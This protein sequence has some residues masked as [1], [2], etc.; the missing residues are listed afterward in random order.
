MTQSWEFQLLGALILRR[1]KEQISHF[2]TEKAKLL[3]AYLAAFPETVHTRE[4]LTESF[5]PDRPQ[6]AGRVSLRQAL[7]SLRR[8]LEPPD[9]AEGTILQA[10]RTQVRLNPDTFQTDLRAWDRARKRAEQVVSVA[11]RL[12]CLEEAIHCYTG[13]L[14]PGTYMEW[15][16]TERQH[17]QEQYLQVL[18]QLIDIQMEWGDYPA[19]IGFAERL[20][21][22]D[23]L[24]EEANERLMRLFSLDGKPGMARRHYDKY[25]HLLHATLNLTPSPGIQTLSTQLDQIAQSRPLV[26]YS[27]S[28][29][30]LSDSS[31]SHPV[32][33]NS[34]FAPERMGS[35]ELPDAADPDSTL[36]ADTESLIADGARS[37][38]PDSYLPL[39]TEASRPRLPLQLTRFFG[40]DAELHLL[41]EWLNDGNARLITLTGIGGVGKT[42]LALEAVQR[43][44]RF[45]TAITFVAL[46][47]TLDSDRLLPAILQAFG[48]PAVA[49][50]DP[51]MRLVT[52]LGTRPQLLIL[53]NFEQLDEMA[54][55][56]LL[57]LLAEIPDVACLVTSRK[58]LNLPGE[59]EL[60]LMPL[61]LPAP[62]TSA[63]QLITNPT[64]QMLV[65]RM[66]ARRPD[67]QVTSS[68]AEAVTAL[69][70][71]LEG[72]PLAVELAAGWARDL[73]VNQIQDR[74]THRFDL[75]VSRQRGVPQRHHSLLA[76][77]ESSYQSLPSPLQRYFLQLSV[78]RGGWREE[79]AEIACDPKDKT[80]LF[81]HTEQ[82]R[83]L[84]EH[85]LITVREVGEQM[86]YG[87]L[88]T[89][90]A[91][92]TEMLTSET[93]QCVAER[94]AHWF[95]AFAQEAASKLH[96]PEQAR[97]L[98]RLEE[99]QDNLRAA[100]DY[101]AKE[102]PLLGLRLANALYWFWYVRGHFREGEKWL[103]LLLECASEAPPFDRA[104]GLV[105]AGHFANCQSH[106]TLAISRYEAARELFQWIGD[107]HGVAHTLCRLGN[108]AQEM[109][110]IEVSVRH[111]AESVSLFRAIDDP[112]G[113]LLA[114]FYYANSLLG[115]IVNPYATRSV[116][117]KLHF[118]EALAIAEAREDHRFIALLYHCL[119]WFKCISGDV[120]GALQGY[121]KALQWQRLLREPLPLSYMLRDL[122]M[123]SVS[124]G[125]PALATTL[126]GAMYGL[127]Q[128][129]SY[130]VAPH[131]E[132]VLIDLRARIDASIPP[133]DY[134]Q[135]FEAGWTL[136]FDQCLT[137]ALEATEHLS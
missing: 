5:W 20:L 11:E 102:D 1:G 76:A 41:E 129:L 28:H 92:G 112:S 116:Q 67:F 124:Q 46:S 54:A 35:S 118:E 34:S 65:D 25:C 15:A 123:L 82:L 2:P 9:V 78:F 26:V 89:L 69:C 95:L 57:R 97:W 13:P 45:G 10:N 137:L 114:L 18:L 43:R 50:I 22:T 104:W 86:R 27:Q 108:A 31:Q 75:L 36:G 7:S 12:H 19:A 101:G 48:V 106:N 130:P 72:I 73:T 60:A 126:Y 71:R 134:R 81:G 103:T 120:E 44:T 87:M 63:Q 117:A 51:F 66:R 127:R 80:S 74:L 33:D 88:E 131:E 122:S 100:L 14:L 32:A 84:R 53:D 128:R 77:I 119:C 39:A 42:R 6:E 61:P 91:F 111:C 110:D 109:L 49:S 56:I 4:T 68:N 113:L 133:N 121:R 52:V 47:E 58:A 83:T 105:A 125:V 30:S 8:L 70:G 90:R 79:M 99:E 62:R 59:R 98:D 132:A 93:A 94:H 136:D 21:K 16:L 115:E 17:R 3:L 23:P 85:S 55:D 96:G 107:R 38:I 37:T 135:A 29:S 40:R 64:V 24:H